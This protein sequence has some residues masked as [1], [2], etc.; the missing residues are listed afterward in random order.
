MFYWSCLRTVWWLILCVN[1]T[2]LKDAQ[3]AGK[4]LFL[5]VS[6][7]V[8]LEE[9]SIWISR[10]SKED[11]PHQRGWASSN[12]LGAWRK[13]KAEEGPFSLNWDIHL[14][15]PSDFG[16][17]FLGQDWDLHH[18]FPWFSALWVWTGPPASRWQIVVLLGFHNLR[19]QHFRIN[20]FL[21]MYI[22]PIGS[23]SLKSPN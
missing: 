7:R 9:I 8:F 14:L 16:A 18:W 5:D 4:T 1:L 6:V 12:P 13:Q 11:P 20:L 23:V 21:Y 2:G 22:C 15:L 3:N 19:R 17:P 10:L